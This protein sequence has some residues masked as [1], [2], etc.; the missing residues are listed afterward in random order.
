MKNGDINNNN[1]DTRGRTI[2][3]KIIIVT[4]LFN[5]FQFYR[6]LVLNVLACSKM[7]WTKERWISRNG[8]EMPE[9]NLREMQ[10]RRKKKGGR[11]KLKVRSGSRVMSWGRLSGAEESRELWIGGGG[12]GWLGV[13][14]CG[15]FRLGGP[16][17]G[18]KKG[19]VI[20]H[21]R[22]MHTAEQHLDPHG[23]R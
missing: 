9:W 19:A 23:W 5:D 3:K 6:L 22:H 14:L 11:K 7:E 16:C 17:V 2:G 12:G 21:A 13:C 8:K 4:T 1:K 20:R 15:G 18:G 10:Q